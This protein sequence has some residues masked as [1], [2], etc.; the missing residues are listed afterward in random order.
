[1]STLSGKAPSSSPG[2]SMRRSGVLLNDPC[3]GLDTVYDGAADMK[4]TAYIFG[5]KGSRWSTS[6]TYG[7]SF[8]SVTPRPWQ[9]TPTPAEK[10]MRNM[11]PGVYEPYNDTH[12]LSASIS[13]QSRGRTGPVGFPFDGSRRSPPFRSTVSRTHFTTSEKRGGLSNEDCFVLPSD[14]RREQMARSHFVDSLQ[15][16]VTSQVF[17]PQRVATPLVRSA[18]GY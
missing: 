14:S 10:V 5:P 6:Q 4:A 13:W 8:R 3:Q 2:G 15:R 7:A 18:P 9:G 1:M 11:G 16:R 12:T 17:A